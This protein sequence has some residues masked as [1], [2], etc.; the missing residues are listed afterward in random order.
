VKAPYRPG[1][2]VDRE[3]LIE[4]YLP[5]VRHVLGRLAVTLPVGL[6]R[7]DLYSVGVCGLI[8]A[9]DSYDPAKGAS[10]KT[11]SYLTIRGA[12]LDELRRHDPVP[13]SRRDKIRELNAV[14]ERL[15]DLLGRHA[16][17]QEIAETLD[18]PV[19]QVEKDLLAAHTVTL[20]SLETEQGEEGD[21]RELLEAR[22]AR[23]PGDEAS[24]REEVGRL[25]QAIA[26][27]PDNER[28][29]VVLYHHEDLL[30]REIGE[31]LGV[32]ESRV[33]QILT[34]AYFHLRSKLGE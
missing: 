29:V 33:C 18:V 2:K 11:Y 28:K 19:E 8:H 15:R 23:D 25:E 20:L 34:K 26:A 32:T 21:L 3:R 31:L 6:D 1:E 13:R 24:L 12:I 22:D 27:L 30:L 17:P 14:M 7:D 4:D 5:L 10:F 16:T 9:A